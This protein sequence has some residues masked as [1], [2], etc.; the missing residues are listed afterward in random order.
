MRRSTGLLAAVLPLVFTGCG[1][2]GVQFDPPG[3]PPPLTAGCQGGLGIVQ[4]TD[5]QAY[6]QI[7]G[8]FDQLRHDEGPG[9]PP[10]KM[11][12]KIDTYIRE[13]MCENDIPGVG[14]GIVWQGNLVYVKGY[15]LA[16]GWGTPGTG[17]D[18]PVRGQRTRF[19]WASV[20]K[21]IT[22]LASVIASLE[23]D[24]QGTPYFDLDA[25]LQSSYRCT[26]EVCAYQIPSSYYPDWFDPTDDNPVPWP[27][28]I[29]PVP[30]TDDT[31]AFTPRRLLAHRCGVMHYGDGDPADPSGSPSAA[32]RAANAGFVW[33]V[34]QWTGLPLVHLPGTD[35]TYSSYGY[36]MAGAALDW[37]VPGTYWSYVK[38]RI[39]DMTQPSPM[40]YL[41]PDD[42]NDPAYAAAPWFTAQDRAHGY[43]QDE[44][45]GE[46]FLNTT[47]DDVSWK[48][49][50]GGFI[51]T[52]A[53][54]ALF[55]EGLLNNRFLDASGMDLYLTP[56]ANAAQ[57]LPGTPTEGYAF[58][59]GVG[60][61]S[62]ERIG[63]HNGGQQDAATRLV[64]YPDGLDPSVG[65]LGIVL[66][67][68]ARYF[69]RNA[70]ANQV[71][72]FLRNPYVPPGPEG[73]VFNGTDPRNPDWAADDFANRQTYGPYADQGEYVDPE[74]DLYDEQ[75]FRALAQRYDPNFV[76]VPTHDPIEPTED[77][78]AL[79]TPE[80]A[81]RRILVDPP[82]R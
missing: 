47:P 30:S 38:S 12:T 68:N 1:G 55:A 22:G 39:A 37:A 3:G 80:E 81:A 33:A 42:T 24:G 29:D 20:S 5:E 34:D 69:D 64:I 71:E 65:K 57:G 17:D 67:S 77:D 8:A 25:D 43:S 54:M 35:G 32:E 46:I 52:V 51:S 36:N 41:H 27:L 40:L 79:E 7:G 10:V 9:N 75:P 16:R 74:L 56:Q 21:C 48:L 49:P 11:T 61:K 2:G 14:L 44:T 28:T 58:G 59:I 73:I 45:T 72:A 4:E 82:P 31:Y 63:A 18:V 76:W 66:M 15:G 70:V 13:Y 50:S 23:E 60:V 19:R 53:D 62:G 6:L 78:P 26:S